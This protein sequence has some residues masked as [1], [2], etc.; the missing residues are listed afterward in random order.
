[1]LLVCQRPKRASFISTVK[2]E[3]GMLL[4][5]VCQRPKRASFISTDNIQV[6]VRRG[7]AV[8]TP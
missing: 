5:H 1:M 2:R 6:I 4:Q 8:S 7:R 3:F